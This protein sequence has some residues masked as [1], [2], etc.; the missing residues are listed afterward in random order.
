MRIAVCVKEVLDSRLPLQVSPD[1]G[2][3]VQSAAELIRLINPA[4]RAALEIALSIRDR[5]PGSTVAVFSVCEESA[6]GALHYA[7]ARGADSVERMERNAGESGPPATALK[8]AS[9][10]SGAHYELICCGDETLDNSSA[11]VGPLLA[12]LLGLPQVTA[13]IR[14]RACDTTRLRIERR[15]ERGHGE[16]VEAELPVLV[17]FKAEAVEPKYVSLRRLEQARAREIPLWRPLSLPQAVSLPQWPAE[18]NL[19][20]RARVK[21]KFTLEATLSAAERVKMIMAGGVRAEQ[22]GGNTSVVEGDPDYLSEQLFRFLKHH[23]FV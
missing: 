6:A 18:K 5:N 2:E 17:T 3:I 20:P 15:L 19:P 21:K 4:D 10:L 12:E 9:R 11:M 8:L 7:L 23:E 13:A 14:L 22:P 1:S 16:V